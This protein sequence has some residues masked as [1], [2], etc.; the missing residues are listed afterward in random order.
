MKKLILVIVLCA[1]V[2]CKSVKEN[3]NEIT[4]TS[5]KEIV[6][7]DYTIVIDKIIS[8]SRCPQGVNCVWAGELVME[9]SVWQNKALNETIQLTFSPKTRDENLV[10][11][12]KYIPQNKKLKSYIVSP[13][14][15]E[16]QIELK[17]YKIQLILE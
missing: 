11:F 5:K 12:E 2:A 3:S 15:T 7:N 4:I 1:F 9:V 16:N 13:T 10:W 6:V 17:E 14:K 8:D